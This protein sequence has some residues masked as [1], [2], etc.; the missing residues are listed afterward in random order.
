MF[1]RQNI[2]LISERNIVIKIVEYKII[3]L[4]VILIVVKYLIVVEFIVAPKIKLY[5][6]WIL[7]MN[8]KLIV[9]VD[10]ALK[11]YNHLNKANVFQVKF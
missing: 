8:Y 3:V 9:V 5:L 4:F 2:N 10:K 6:V 7:K 11:T 1:L